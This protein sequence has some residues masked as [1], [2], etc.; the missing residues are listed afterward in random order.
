MP[1]DARRRAKGASEVARAK[2]CG[3]DIYDAGALFKER[4]LVRDDSLF[5]PASGVWSPLHVRAVGERVGVEDLG[6]GSFIEKLESQLD[7]LHASEIQV[8]AELLYMLLL[9][10]ADTSGSKKREHI[11]RILGMLPA[12]VVMPRELDAALDSG[13]VANF[14]AAKAYR[15]AGLRF[16]ARLFTRLKDLP[17]EE[18][19]SILDAPWEFRA[20]VGDVRTSTD[21]MQANAFLHLLFPGQFEYMVSEA[22]RQKLIQTFQAAPGIAD[23]DNPDRK[24]ARIREL[25]SVGGDP[26]L[27]LYEDPF[28][29]IWKEEPTPRW[30]E[31]IDWTG[32]LYGR[33]DF[34]EN[35]R[36]YKLEV[37]AKVAAARDAQLSGGPDWLDQLRAAFTHNLNNLTSWRAHDSFLKWCETRDADAAR[38]L[39]DLW[40]PGN[41]TS[42]L[43]AFLDEL[44]PDALTGPGTRVSVASFLLLGIDA[45]RYPFY[46][47]TV[48]SGFRKLL[49][50]GGGETV[51]IDPESVYRPEELAA[52]LGLDGRRVRDFLRTTFPRPGSEHGGA[53][54]LTPEQAQSVL[55]EFA[56]DIDTGSGE[57]TYADWTALLEELRLRMLAAG[58]PLR[59]LLDAQGIA[60]WLVRAPAPD[61]WDETDRAAFEAFRKGSTA[62]VAVTTEESPVKLPPGDVGLPEVTPDLAARLHLPE[63]WLHRLFG[64][65]AEK[66]QLILYGPPGTGKTFV[67]QHIGRHISEHGGS[68]RLVQFHPSYT[69]EDFFEGYRPRHHDGGALSFDLVPGALREIARD[70]HES[71]DVPHLLIIDEINRGNIA[72]I[73]GELY[74]LLE[75][76]DQSIR[77][78]YSRDEEFRLPKNLFFVGTMNTADRSIALVDSALR[79]RFYF[80]GLIPTRE[81][82]DRVLA[83]WLAAHELPPEPAVLLAELNRT[84]DDED[85]SIGP[86]YFMTK[87]AG[88]PDLERVWA[89]AVMPLLEEHYYGTGRDLEAEFGLAAIRK[90]VAAA[91][92]ATEAEP[93]DDSA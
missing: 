5:A 49:G 90:R 66:K 78:Q 36:D 77:L 72:K 24:I 1:P 56:D 38:L 64:L 88:A 57:A 30:S 65:L 25:A 7:G 71:P 20:L 75:Y 9:P 86:S 89:H 14:A 3:D 61:D 40:G 87:D 58:T 59:D 2:W 42:N 48:H 10:E 44:P 73:F 93:D 16:L 46:K 47:A 23:A 8:G 6:S 54:F 32:R 74:F 35:E 17:G 29:R 21:A 63:A 12:E 34:D 91:A 62:K 84:I 19:R 52:R 68:S 55:D 11:S 27:D 28:Q 4:C 50:L 80:M 22:H 83:D 41:P 31:A 67:A 33:D 45:T 13:G 69:Y 26:D 15:D 92:D 37:A 79:R 18:R 85:F 53:W 43:H 70:A 81:P 39:R 76:R 60:W 51:E 82:V